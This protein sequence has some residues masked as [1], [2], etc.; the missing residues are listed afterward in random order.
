MARWRGLLEEDDGRLVLS[1]R[2]DFRKVGRLFALVGFVVGAPL[3]IAS[4]LAFQYSP[5]IGVIGA[6]FG[7][8]GGVCALVGLAFWG[9]YGGRSIVD[10]KKRVVVAP[11]HQHFFFDDVIGVHT[12]SY[13]HTQRTGKGGTVQT[14]R[15]QV[16]VITKD[17]D[18]EAQA[19]VRQ[20]EA[21][22]EE[23]LQ[24]NEDPLTPGQAAEIQKDLND[25]R[26]LLEGGTVLLADH[27]D[28]LVVWRACELL[29][30]QLQV[31]LMDTSGDGMLLRALA[32]LDMP[33][34]ERLFRLGQTPTAPKHSAQGIET[35]EAHGRR[36]ITWP[37]STDPVVAV[38]TVAGIVGATA[39]IASLVGGAPGAML[40]GMWAGFLM[41]V[42]VGIAMYLFTPPR[43]LVLEE[44]QI[45]YKAW[46]HGMR[47]IGVDE[48]EAVR[49]DTSL[50]PR[51]VLLADRTS[52]CLALKTPEQASWLGQYLEHHLAAWAPTPEGPY[53]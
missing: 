36:T 34:G 39:L 20:V 45:S 24:D 42:G 53:R 50:H 5:L 11:D 52:L 13:V 25:V 12:T 44:K 2:G 29:A 41:L 10:P 17:V 48:V 19:T 1:R 28:A 30:R 4:G 6:V 46:C 15:Y 35:Q 43:R 32:E 31:P 7:I 47:A 26:P 3:G 9:I 49:V 23:A 38:G 40:F 14:I 8:S 33:L 51:V 27:G 37:A 16:G 22:V 18:Q 21:A